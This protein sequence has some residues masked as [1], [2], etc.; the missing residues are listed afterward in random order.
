MQGHA[1]L[2]KWLRDIDKF[3][4]AFVDGIP[5]SNDKSQKLV[6]R[7]GPIRKTHYGEYWDFTSDLK[8][9][10]TAYTNLALP[11]HTDTSYFSD[12]IGLQFFHL[13]FHSGS[14][15]ESLFVDGFKAAKQLKKEQPWAFDA[16]SE[17]RISAH[18]S[19]DKGTH[20]QPNESFPII[21]L[22]AAGEVT[23]IRFN[24][25]DR[26]PLN[27][28]ES[29]EL[30]YSS[31]SEWVKILKQKENELWIKLEPGRGVILDNWRV[32]HGRASFTGKRTM[33]GCYVGRDDF[34][35]KLRVLK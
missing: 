4:I 28:G 3:G 21:K 34:K 25:D 31:L 24:N 15:G 22:N 8:H 9:G 20:L 1:G 2:A 19:G 26:A 13:L 17:L 32:L 27:L 10:D 11:A 5:I 33:S 7:L 6:E 30:F 12:P 35:S 23:Q 29:T 16:L 14:G 18:S